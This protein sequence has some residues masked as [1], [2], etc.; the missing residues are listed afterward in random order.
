MFVFLSKHDFRAL[1]YLYF[2][3]TSLVGRQVI[4]STSILSYHLN[5][6]IRKLLEDVKNDKAKK[7]CARAD[8]RK[9]SMSRAMRLSNYCLETKVE[10]LF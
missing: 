10:Q 5:S 9:L 2:F 1:Y 3:R 8:A 4:R 6:K 7:G